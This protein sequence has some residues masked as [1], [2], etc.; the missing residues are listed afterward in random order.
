MLMVYQ[1]ADYV[2]DNVK[3]TAL[4]LRAK[5]TATDSQLLEKAKNNDSEAF[6]ELVRRNQN[7]VYRTA[8]GYIQAD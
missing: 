5:F 6:G 7:F 8:L 4:K 2:G 1:I 3:K